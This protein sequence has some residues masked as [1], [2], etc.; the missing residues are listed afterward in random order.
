MA[1]GA[2]SLQRFSVLYRG[3]SRG[4]DLETVPFGHGRG[5]TPD[6]AGTSLS[7]VGSR[8]VV[9]VWVAR[10]RVGRG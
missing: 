6:M 10:F 1:S 3:R 5:L 9:G 2:I 4:F 8:V 7:L